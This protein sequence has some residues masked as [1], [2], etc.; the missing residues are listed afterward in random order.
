MFYVAP[1]NAGKIL[2]KIWKFS[3]K[4]HYVLSHHQTRPCWTEWWR[5]KAD[6][7]CQTCCR[8]FQYWLQTE[9]HHP[10][11]EEVWLSRMQQTGRTSSSAWISVWY[12]KAEVLHF[13][14]MIHPASHDPMSGAKSSQSNCDLTSTTSRSSECMS[15]VFC[16]TWSDSFVMTSNSKR[17]R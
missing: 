3:D 16:S 12:N 14:W 7:C 9:L 2:T 15:S 5:P 10:H 1:K 8:S 17:P 6:R 13:Y 4:N 11:P